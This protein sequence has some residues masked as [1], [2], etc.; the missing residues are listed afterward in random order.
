MYPPDQKAAPAAAA[1]MAAILLAGLTG[2]H[3]NCI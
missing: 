2:H 3:R 1:I